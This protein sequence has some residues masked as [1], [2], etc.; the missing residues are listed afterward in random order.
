MELSQVGPPIAAAPPQAVSAPVQPRQPQ[1]SGATSAPTPPPAEPR[2]PSTEQMK[3]AVDEVRSA[4]NAMAQNLQFSVDKETGKTIVKV[5]DANTDQ[6]IRQIPPEEIL[7]IA[8][9]IDTMQHG[10]LIRQKA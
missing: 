8:K 7:A 4:V 10:L 9:A 1:Q 3:Q 5:V 2:Q 6:V